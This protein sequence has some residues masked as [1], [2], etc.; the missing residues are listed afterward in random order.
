[1]LLN[2]EKSA[3]L[4]GHLADVQIL[5]LFDEE[6]SPLTCFQLTFLKVYALTCPLL[7]PVASLIV[8]MMAQ[9]CGVL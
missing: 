5:Y 9:V 3:G 1:M 7:Q 8:S 6:Q 2:L 4:K